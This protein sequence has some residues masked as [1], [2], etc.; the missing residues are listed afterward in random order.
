MQF[1]Q[2]I[3]TLSG[4]ADANGFPDGFLCRD[5]VFRRQLDV[6]ED[7][8]QVSGRSETRGFHASGS[9]WCQQV[10]KGIIAQF[11]CEK[12]PTNCF[13]EAE[14]RLGLDPA[15]GESHVGPERHR[16]GKEVA[17]RYR[18][19]QGRRDL[20]LPPRSGIKDQTQ[21]IRTVQNDQLI[22]GKS[23]VNLIF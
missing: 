18:V 17:P 13:Q 14:Q 8:G 10:K 9:G 2:I 6:P 16:C 1:K 12:D 4:E 11:W 7:G 20:R 5:R 3:V 21:S 19:G 23:R 22:I 15:G